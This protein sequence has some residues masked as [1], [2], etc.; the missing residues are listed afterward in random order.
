MKQ[1]K[2]QIKNKG[3][4]ISWVANQLNIPQPTL[5]MYL[6]EKRE[7]PFEIEFK[8]KQLLK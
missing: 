4:K 1:L 2:N 7:M 6:N 5:S 3:L 8:L